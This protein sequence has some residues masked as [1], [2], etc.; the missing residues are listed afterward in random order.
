MTGQEPHEALRFSVGAEDMTAQSRRTPGTP[1]R[2]SVGSNLLQRA[3]FTGNIPQ[4]GALWGLP[5]RA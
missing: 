2:S 5:M 4:A 3:C 1:T